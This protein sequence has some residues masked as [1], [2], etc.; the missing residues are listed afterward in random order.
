M[1]EKKPWYRREDFWTPVI[2]A[3]AI[4]VLEV[5]GVELPVEAL[6]TVV[7][8]IAGIIWSSTSQ[9][10]AATQGRIAIFQM[11]QEKE[12]RRMEREMDITI[13][14]GKPE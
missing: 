12:I 1:L 7:L 11:T 14:G 3:L 8:L 9:E 6:V 13:K 4:M 2:G 10:N 5:A